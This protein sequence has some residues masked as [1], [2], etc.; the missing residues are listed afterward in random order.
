MDGPGRLARSCGS[1]RL[2]R[3]V[4]SWRG[5]VQAHVQADGGARLAGSG[6]DKVT[7]LVDEPQA[8]AA[9]QFIGRGPV[10]GE[11]IGEVTSVGHLADELSP[12]LPD[13][14]YSA[15]VRM[16]HGVGGKLA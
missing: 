1:V 4:S 16:A 5:P 10:P 13:L 9:Q 3:R 11:R 14:Q 15:A 8:V 7:D 6:L 2:P 12:G